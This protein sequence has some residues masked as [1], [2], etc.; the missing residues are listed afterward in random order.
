M[1]LFYRYKGLKC[2]I[3]LIVL[4]WKN[5]IDICINVKGKHL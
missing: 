2:N 4:K 3:A 1:T 5:I